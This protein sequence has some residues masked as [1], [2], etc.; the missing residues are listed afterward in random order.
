MHTRHLADWQ[1]GRCGS[2]VNATFP[3]PLAKVL[4]LAA[5]DRGLLGVLLT[6]TRSERA[7]RRRSPFGPVSHGACHW[8]GRG[9]R[10]SRETQCSLSPSGPPRSERGGSPRP[11]VKAPNVGPSS[12][13]EETPRLL[14][15]PFTCSAQ[16][17]GCRGPQRGP[18]PRKSAG[19]CTWQRG[20][21]GS[22]G[23]AGRRH[24]G[25]KLLERRV[26]DHA[27]RIHGAQRWGAG[28][29]NRSF[30]QTRFGYRG[31]GPS[32]TEG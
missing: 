28:G 6:R 11:R 24:R 12:A 2:R 20:R 13:T 23:Q 17:E 21:G 10:T 3:L 5:R 15:Q 26:C 7:G 18:T 4:R 22:R 32:E 14:S 1:L 27:A 25:I 30:E 16:A 8:G 19:R 31:R 9:S 29:S